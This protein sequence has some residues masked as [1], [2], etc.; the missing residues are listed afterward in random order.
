MEPKSSPAMAYALLI[1]G[2]VW[3]SYRAWEF[4]KQGRYFNAL[5]C[6]VLVMGLGY[7]MVLRHPLIFEDG[8]GTS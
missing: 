5:I 3:C 1:S 4:A 6:I 2:I 7:L 8:R